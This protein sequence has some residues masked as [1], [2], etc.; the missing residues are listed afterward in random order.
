V[1]GWILLSSQI[2]IVATCDGIRLD[3]YDSF[4]EIDGILYDEC[5]SSELGDDEE[6][7]SLSPHNQPA[8]LPLST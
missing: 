4:F 3:K 5:A 7:G 6:W 8:N 2:Y 1:S